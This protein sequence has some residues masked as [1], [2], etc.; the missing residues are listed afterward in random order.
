MRRLSCFEPRA[1]FLD[2]SLPIDLRDVLELEPRVGRRLALYVHDACPWVH[3][4]LPAVRPQLE[5]QIG[6]FVISGLPF[7]AE[8]PHLQKVRP[9]HHEAGSRAVVDSAWRIEVIRAPDGALSDLHHV[10]GGES[11]AADLLHPPVGVEEHRPY[12]GHGGVFPHRRGERLDPSGLHECV[13]V[14]E[15]DV[16]APRKVHTDVVALAEEAIDPDL[17]QD[18]VVMLCLTL[19][20]MARSSGLDPLSTTMMSRIRSL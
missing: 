12:G 11:H 16:V 18:E 19:R 4:D 14:E 1:P 3:H 2:E 17:D 10:P 15:D 9:P 6:V 13:V 7:E 20:K 5:A 8:A